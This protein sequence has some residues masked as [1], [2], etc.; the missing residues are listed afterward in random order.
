M[1]AR[2]NTSRKQYGLRALAVVL[3]ILGGIG[4]YFGVHNF[5]IRAVGIAAIMAS[6]YLARSSNG[7]S[8][9]GLPVQSGEVDRPTMSGPGRLLW[10]VSLSL[11]PAVT[12]AWYLLH[13]D[14]VHG[15]HAVWPVYLFAGVALI[16]A[17]VW[18]LLVATISR[19]GSGT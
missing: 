11:V 17:L 3:L 6:A 8:R 13:L 9:S 10:I 16:C 4:I 7:Q 5:T 19:G 1:I 14:A 12:G 15:G 2:Q 18:S